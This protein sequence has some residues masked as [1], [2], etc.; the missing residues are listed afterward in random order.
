MT[1]EAFTYED[2]YELLRTEKF[3]TD[4]EQISVN[5][6]AR[7]KAYLESKQELLKKEGSS[8][9]ILSSHKKAK[10]QMEIDNALRALKDLYEIRERKIINRALV[11][12]RTESGLKDTTNMFDTE[13]KLYTHLLDILK[14]SKCSF[15]DLVEKSQFAEE[16]TL[17]EDEST[18]DAE[19]E[20]PAVEDSVV[21]KPAE[22]VKPSESKDSRGDAEQSSAP[23]E[24][25]EETPIEEKIVFHNVKFLQECP[26][27]FGEDLQQYGPFAVGDECKL[28]NQLCSILETQNKVERKE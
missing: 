22:D 23:E 19:A 18:D 12:T 15:F 4:L 14:V 1:I 2:I 17:V 3:A 24:P 7:I 11:S 20:Q 13:S 28:P 21:E 16:S 9:N 5:D 8:T 25:K 6:L 10:I 27:I 26:E